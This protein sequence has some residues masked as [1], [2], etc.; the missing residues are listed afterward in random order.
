MLTLNKYEVNRFD[1]YCQFKKYENFQSMLSIFILLIYNTTCHGIQMKAPCRWHGFHDRSVRYTWNRP[2][3]DTIPVTLSQDVYEGSLWITRFLWQ[4]HENSIQCGPKYT[5]SYDYQLTHY[6]RRE[7]LCAARKFVDPLS[8][9]P[10][11]LSEYV[12]PLVR[13]RGHERF[14]YLPFVCF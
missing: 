6:D 4:D 5:Y 12:Q 10:V 3:D 7:C 13:P 8:S 1:S 11:L 14:I 9:W 2:P